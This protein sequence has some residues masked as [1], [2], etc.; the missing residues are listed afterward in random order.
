[1]GDQ[2]WIYGTSA[3]WAGVGVGRMLGD[4]DRANNTATARDERIALPVFTP[5]ATFAA[6]SSIDTECGSL[7]NVNGPI[8]AP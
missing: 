1:M 7:A 6:G 2:L 4:V 8:P 3:V 5:C